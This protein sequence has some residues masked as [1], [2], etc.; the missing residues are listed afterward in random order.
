MLKRKLYQILTDWKEKRSSQKA[1]FIMGARQVGKSTLARLFG[2]ENFDQVIEVNF[3]EDPL[4][5]KFFKNSDPAQI[6]SSL[7]AWSRKSIVPGSTLIILDE[8]QECPQ[9]RTAVK[10]LV[11]EG[12]CSYIETGSLLGIQ[13]KPVESYPVGFEE[14]VNMYPLDFEEF[15]WAMQLPDE[16]L[17]LLKDCFENRKTVSVGIHEVMLRLFYTYIV[18]GGMPEVVQTY[19]NT[20][21]IN[22]VIARQGSILDLYRNDIS[23][24]VSGLMSLKVRQIFDSIPAQLDDKKRRFRMNALGKNRQFRELEDSFLWLEEAGVAL[25]CYNTSAP[26]TPLRLNE[27]RSLFKLYMNDCGLLCAASLG[28]IQTDLLMGDVQ[29]NSGSILENVFAQAIASKGMDLYYYDSKKI[30]ELDFVVQNGKDVDILEIK[31]GSDY[32]KHPALTKALK[33]EGWVFRQKIVFCKGNVR[34]EDGILYL[35]FYMILFYACKEARH[36]MWDP[37]STDFHDSM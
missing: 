22:E 33:V 23:K 20:K 6:L 28:D 2:Q 19:V 13:N 37:L 32:K 18:V 27:K 7:T 1:L 24:F 26:V 3:L 16:T 15:L 10:F 21:D 35:P 4:T 11:Q 29:I 14:Q 17:L 12:S 8:I 9:A 34:E 31:S 36:L 25:P 30:G 5:R